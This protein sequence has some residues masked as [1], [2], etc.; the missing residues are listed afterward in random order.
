MKSNGTVQRAIAVSSSLVATVLLLLMLALLIV[1]GTVYQVGHGVYEAQQHIFNAWLV[2]IGGFI[3]YPG[4]KLIISTL[5]VNLVAA[6]FRRSRWSWKN[7]GLFLVHFG[8]AVMFVNAGFSYFLRQESTLTLGEGESSD[9]A[10]R[11][12]DQK[13][14]GSEMPEV[15]TLPVAVRLNTFVM[16]Y[17]PGTTAVMDY[18][19]HVHVKG[20]GIDRDVVVSMNKPFR[21]HDYT[22]YQSSYQS[23]GTAAISTLAVVKNPGR[24]F[25]YIASIMIAAG[26]IIHFLMQLV[27]SQRKHGA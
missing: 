17:H 12:A 5:F 13:T 20:E 6:G 11:A 4:V 10:L 18:E 7:S 27:V 14:A 25:P 15:M 23:G 3:P 19:S 1:Y 22:F 24:I 2:F 9:R 8:I 16:K 21:Y 26:L